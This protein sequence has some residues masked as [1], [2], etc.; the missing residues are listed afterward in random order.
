MALHLLVSSHGRRLASRS[1]LGYQ[2]KS[3]PMCDLCRSRQA[4]G[5]KARAITD[6]GLKGRTQFQT[7]PQKLMKY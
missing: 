4:D 2:V 6:V 1:A 5:W 3:L 7:L